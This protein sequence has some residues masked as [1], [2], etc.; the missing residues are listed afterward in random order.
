MYIVS[1]AKTVFK[2]VFT[3]VGPSF[4]ATFEHLG[5][6]QIVTSLSCFCRHF[7]GN[8]SYKLAELVPLSSS[9]LTFLYDINSFDIIINTVPGRFTIQTRKVDSK[10]MISNYVAWMILLIDVVVI[11]TAQLHS[12]KSVLVLCVGSI[13]LTACW[14]SHSGPGWI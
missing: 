4:A 8:C 9:I 2:N 14:T 7:F 6:R 11:T 10:K 13:L 5:D 3:F 1:I 12:A